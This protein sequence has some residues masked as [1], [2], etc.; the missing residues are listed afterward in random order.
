VDTV[1]NIMLLKARYLLK[2]SVDTTLVTPF[3]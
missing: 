1:K 3:F 2:S